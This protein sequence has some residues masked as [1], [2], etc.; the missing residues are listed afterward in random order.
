MKKLIKADIMYMLVSKSFL[1]ICILFAFFLVAHS[2]M[3]YDYVCRS[4]RQYEK[5]YNYMIEV[6]ANID[7]Q[8]DIDYI[9]HDDGSIENPLSFFKEQLEKSVSAIHPNNLFTNFAESCTLFLPIIAVLVAIVLVSYDEKN[10]TARLKITRN[11]KFCFDFS[12]QITGIVFM[13][14]IILL[15]LVFFVFLNLVVY[16][17]IKSSFDI[18]IVE[19]FFFGSNNI[20]YQMLYTFL[21]AIIFF[22]IGYTISNVFHCYTAIAVIITIYSFWA[23]PIFKFD[24]INLKCYFESKIFNFEGVVSA[25]SPIP[26]SSASAIIMV[27]VI[28]MILL[29]VNLLA[30]TKKSAFN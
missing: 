1:W 12:K 13:S 26:I 29:C 9:I 16:N 15:A 3:S 10:K 14:F 27:I 22:E 19:R 4:F 28:M 21:V 8:L 11:G 24:P 30:L 25:T 6:D 20:F 17:K 23:K 7:E 2:W 5:T 18:T